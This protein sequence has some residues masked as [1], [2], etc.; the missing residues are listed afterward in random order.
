MRLITVFPLSKRFSPLETPSLRHTYTV[1]GTCHIMSC[2]DID[3]PKI[4]VFL[5][6]EFRSPLYIQ[7][8]NKGVSLLAL[9]SIA[10]TSPGVSIVSGIR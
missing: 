6:C 4:K 2:I 7:Q 10:S 5:I 8:V 1:P 9:W 3:T